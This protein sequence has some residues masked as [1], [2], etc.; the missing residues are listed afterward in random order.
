MAR[1]LATTRSY[2]ASSLMT[3]VGAASLPVV[4]TLSLVVALVYAVNVIVFDWELYVG[5]QQNVFFANTLAN[6]GRLYFDWSDE[7]LLFPVYPPGYY[8]A[9]APLSALAGSELWA[10]R[11]F[12]LVC[13]CLGA[14]AAGLTARK[15]DA[16]RSE[17]FVSAI[18]FLSVPVCMIV[19][20]NARPDSLA[21]ALTG[22]ALL[23]A[24][25]WEDT[26]GR[27]VLWLAALACVGLV[28]TRPNYGPIVLALG[29]AF[30][31][32]DRSAAL[33]F[34]AYTAGGTVLVFVLADV[35]TDG[36]FVRNM[37]DFNSIGYSWSNLI[38][39]V[40]TVTLPFLHPVYV[41]A[42]VEV[43]IVLRA[44]RSAPSAVW[45][46]LASIV[47]LL[48]AVRLGAADN[49]IVPLAFTS[50]VLMG[51]ALARVRRSAGAPAAAAVAFAVALLMLPSV[52]QGVRELPGKLDHLADLDAANQAAVSELTT[53][54]GAFLGDRL[55]LAL[56]AG[57][58]DQIDGF[59]H[60]QFAAAGV[61]DAGPLA[62]RIRARE[63]A[64]I[65]TSVD[66][67]TPV[68][69]TQQLTDAMRASYC[70]EF[71]E[72]VTFPGQSIWLWRPC[73]PSTEQE[74]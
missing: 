6:D 1:L 33:R 39:V 36:A 65:Q 4:L 54:D 23:A 61:W 20:F 35:L 3:R 26:R 70:P 45:A 64:L 21:V 11:L 73:N 68:T 62:E 14:L 44:W 57:G 55:D 63:Y 37:Q 43:A 15:L 2:G 19:M 66:P 13:C 9:V 24:T 72:I 10:G 60:P 40:D 32:R 56:A 18:A 25:H 8:V 74:P 5:E 41:V 59:N 67:A 53:A 50:S 27:L 49:Y 42:A 48:T 31:L 30:L 7:Q 52:V 29:I 12:S 71:S 28:L 58:G 34:A 69:W 22:G 47:V 38:G 46:W 51:P 17:A 16:N